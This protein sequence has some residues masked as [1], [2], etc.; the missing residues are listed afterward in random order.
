MTTVQIRIDEKTKK[1]AK[2]VLDK[3]GVDMSSA[4]KVYLRQ[5]VITKGIPFRLV[6]ENGFT[7]AEEEEI[8]KISMDASKGKNV[9]RAMEAKEAIEYL[10][11]L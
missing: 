5:I 3:I 11:S 9:T 4:V 7:P 10:K 2:K 6:T 8:L 1:S